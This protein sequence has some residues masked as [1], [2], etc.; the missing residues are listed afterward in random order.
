ML[1][2]TTA[3]SAADARIHKKILGSGNYTIL[4]FS[5]DDLKDF[6]K[7]LKLFG[8]NGILLE[9]ITETVKNDVKVQRGG[10]LSTLLSVLGSS[11]LTSMLTGKGIKEKSNKVNWL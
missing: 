10:F 9:G 3:T 4:I 11:L 5:N 1:G 8:D 2:F 6:L 7:V